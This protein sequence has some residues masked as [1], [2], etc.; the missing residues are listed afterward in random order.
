MIPL[1]EADGYNVVAPPN[2]LR[3]L[4]SDSA[5]LASYLTTITGPI[6]LVGH[7][8][9][10]AVITNAATGNP[11]VKALVY[12][13]AFEPAQG[14]TLQ[15]L[16]FALPGSCLGGGGDLSN[17]FNFVTDPSLPAG[18]PDLF[19]KVAPGT[20]FPGWNACF[21]TDVPS[22]EAAL[23][24]VGQRPLA[25]GRLQRRL[26][27]SGVGDD[28]VLGDHRH[29]RSSD[30]ACGVAV[31]GKSCGFKDRVRA[32]G[33]SLDD[34]PA[35]RGRAPNHQ[36]RRRNDVATL[37]TVTSKV[38]LRPGDP[39]ARSR[40]RQSIESPEVGQQY[41][42]TTS[43]PRES[44]VAAAYERLAAETD[45][46]F[47]AVLR[48]DR[49]G[50]IRIA[51]TR[52]REPYGSDRELIAAVRAC[53]VLEVTTAAIGPRRMHPVLGCEFGGPFDRFRAIHDL[54]G[55]VKT[56]FGFDL[57][58]EYAAWLTQTRLHSGLARRA[59]ATELY[60]VNSARWIAGE[61]PDHKAMLID[62]RSRR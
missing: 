36:G 12:V 50:S 32:G 6:V 47:G 35:E 52:C 25:A 31:H 57:A 54:V 42:N 21:A 60:G 55:H 26:R 58:G 20:D 45:F 4:P 1:L 61:A 18:D 62:D 13:D 33:S 19:I 51:F 15:Q 7:S 22:S 16:T 59:L 2:P 53:R 44:R 46:L 34:H 38:S 43:S 5:Y 48:D 9:G 41:L 17:V 39:A 14:E 30:T 28:S 37:G 23:L 10:G 29:G 3:G 49:P 8:Y 24:A 27:A 56:G 40:P 11:N